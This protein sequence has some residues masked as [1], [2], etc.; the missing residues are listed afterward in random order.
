MEKS[1]EPQWEMMHWEPATVKAAREVAAILAVA[2]S[3][4]S[5]RAFTGHSVA[6]L[7]GSERTDTRARRARRGRCRTSFWRRRR[8]WCD[9]EGC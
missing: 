6:A 9:R 5:C 1:S 2:A 4:S 7:C 8:S 3:T